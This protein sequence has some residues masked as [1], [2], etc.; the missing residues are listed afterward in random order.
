M[1]DLKIS[2]LGSITVLT[3]ATDVLP[4]VDV[5]GTTKKITTNQILGSGG[6]A[7]L[8]SATITGDLTVRTNKL[9]VNATGV[10]VGTTSVFGDFTIQSGSNCRFE[11][12]SS[13]GGTSIENLNN[14]RNA[15]L[16]MTMYADAYIWNRLGTTAMTLNSTGLGV[17]A[18]PSYKLSVAG[19]ANIGTIGTAGRSLLI[20]SS[21]ADNITI[22]QTNNGSGSHTFDIK[23]PGWS[24]DSF[25]VYSGSTNRLKLTGDGNLG[26]G[27]TP[28]AWSNPY[29]CVQLS[30]G[31][32]SVYPTTDLYISQNAYNSGGWKRVA[33]GYASQYIQ[34]NSEHRFLVAGTDPTVDSAIAFT[35]AMTLDASGNLLV[36]TTAL[37]ASWDTRL[38][39]S[40][41]IGTTRWAVGPYSTATNFVISAASG[42]GVYLNGTAA[43]SWTSASDE[44]LKDIIEPISNAIA[45]VGSLRAVIG[46][47]KSDD[48]NTRKSFLMAQDVQSVLPEAVDASN[49]DRLGLAYTDVI[50]LLVAAIKE[51]TARVQTLE[52]K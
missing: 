45:K 37:N 25:N 10:G 26:I 21:A 36:G 3:P 24:T 9:F 27:V 7:T 48:T 2:Q 40:S 31:S 35:Q 23:T 41:N 12:T 49:P 15:Y 11:V 32:L 52:A 20:A 28:S 51:L 38:T 14:A 19:T 39:L 42:G 8:A 50:P 47:F 22:E 17:G 16:N 33:A 4:V 1:A 5:T 29:K 34:T 46:K 30:G 44:R 13:A 6:T 18:S 43:T